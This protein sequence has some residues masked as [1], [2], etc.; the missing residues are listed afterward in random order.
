[1][2]IITLCGGLFNHRR[3]SG[4]GD[5]PALPNSHKQHG[6]VSLTNSR[7]SRVAGRGSKV[8]VAGPKSRSRVQ[9]RGRGS[10]VAVA[11]PIGNLR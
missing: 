6:S 7:G 8:A 10:Y 5:S 4:K 1:M 9:C 3:I 2:L 11:G